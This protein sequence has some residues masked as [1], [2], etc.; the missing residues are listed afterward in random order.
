MEKVK[1]FFIIAALLVTTAAVFAGRSRFVTAGALY[2]YEY[3]IGYV[4]ISNSA[5]FWGLTTTPTGS[6]ATMSNALG[7]SYP[8][9]VYSPSIG[10]Y[11]LVYAIGW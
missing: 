3:S 7:F 1:I 2:V 6:P 9:Y 5:I 4:I 8:L 10:A 11:T